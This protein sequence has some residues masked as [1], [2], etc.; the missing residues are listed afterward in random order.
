[1]IYQYVFFRPFIAL[2]SC[3]LYYNGLLH[4]GGLKSGNP[5]SMFLTLFGFLVLVI[6]MWGLLQV[7]RVFGLILKP[8]NVGSKFLALKVY[9][10]FHVIQG[11][12]FGFMA[13]NQETE[14]KMLMIV[15]IEYSVLCVEML[16]FLQ[17]H[18]ICGS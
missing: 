9:I 17:V 5:L 8:N 18:G 10:W 11:F 15:R 14:Q 7:Y 3:V 16:R 6:A 1:M 13:S 2:L 4:E 12:I